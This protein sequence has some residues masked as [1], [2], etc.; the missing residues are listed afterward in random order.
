MIDNSD[1]PVDDDADFE[2]SDLDDNG[3][4]LDKLTKHQRAILEFFVAKMRLRSQ[5]KM[6]RW[7]LISPLTSYSCGHMCNPPSHPLHGKG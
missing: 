2:L 7:A 3:G 1:D 5:K 6:K 4:D